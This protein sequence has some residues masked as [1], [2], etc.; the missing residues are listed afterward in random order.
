M[1]QIEAVKK[2][3]YEKRAKRK[4]DDE[5][6][7]DSASAQESDDVEVD[8]VASEDQQMS[9]HDSQFSLDLKGGQFADGSNKKS[10]TFSGL[11][12]EILEADDN[13]FYN[14]LPEKVLKF[15]NMG[16]KQFTY[17]NQQE[18]NKKSASIESLP[19]LD[20]IKACSHLSQK[21]TQAVKTFC[22]Q[23][24]KRG[25]AKG[26]MDTII[27]L[28]LPYYGEKLQQMLPKGEAYYNLFKY[29]FLSTE[30]KNKVFM[31][32]FC[33]ET[34]QKLLE[35]V[36]TQAKEIGFLEIRQL[37]MRVNSKDESAYSQELLDQVENWI[38]KAKEIGIE[39]LLVSVLKQ[40]THLKY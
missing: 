39:K 18:L 25:K 34:K 28:F 29:R 31:K 2:E 36:P 3:H 33:P 38:G 37:Q 35:M 40:T 21:Q 12:N 22:A 13:E 19:A 23:Y 32:A 7:A 27:K 9:E 17:L 20:L 15:S 6:V 30:D 8:S 26:D 16:L 14:A 10:D 4:E 5:V 24:L 11:L 1:E